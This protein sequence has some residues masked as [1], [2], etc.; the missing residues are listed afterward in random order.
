GGW[1][2]RMTSH[3]PP[4]RG[5]DLMDRDGLSHRRRRGSGAGGRRGRGRRLRP[6]VTVLEGRAL[7]SIVT[8]TST[9]AD[10]SARTYG[11]RSS[12]RP[13][14]LRGA[15]SDSPAC[16]RGM[17]S[18]GAVLSPGGRENETNDSSQQT[19][20]QALSREILGRGDRARAGQSR[21]QQRLSGDRE[22][23]QSSW[24]HRPTGKCHSRR[25]Q[26]TM[27]T[28]TALATALLAFAIPARAG[29]VLDD[30]APGDKFNPVDGYV[31]S[32]GSDGVLRV[33]AQFT[34]AASGELSSIRLALAYIAGTNAFSVSLLD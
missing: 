21:R 6:A 13:R 16:L 4:V 20:R 19:Y 11:G 31:V 15:R 34:A 7:L 14:T 2:A 26:S 10:P 25:E 29:I 24:T 8:V 33:A 9:A 5:D 23:I 17:S 12:R 28:I 32:G 18:I 3:L 27:R 1:G 22:R 30:F